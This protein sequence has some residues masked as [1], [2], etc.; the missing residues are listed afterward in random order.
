MNEVLWQPDPERQE[1][2][3]MALFLRLLRQVQ[4]DGFSD[5]V[6]Y[7]SLWRWS[8]AEPEAFWQRVADFCGIDGALVRRIRE[9]IRANATPRR[10]PAKILA[11]T[12]LPR[13]ESNKISEI[14]V[15]EV[16]HGR[17]VTNTEALLN[18][19]VL[20]QFSDRSELAV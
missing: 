5:V 2:S 18:P 7:P 13:T 19:E 11:V 4:S 15:R 17:P 3:N 14:A 12:D 8:V 16:V 10:V 1:A 9:V 6:D 20:E